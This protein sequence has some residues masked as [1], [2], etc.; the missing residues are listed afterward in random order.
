MTSGDLEQIDPGRWRDRATG[1]VLVRG[2]ALLH[3]VFQAKYSALNP[4][5][6]TGDPAARGRWDIPEHVTLY[7]GA[8]PDAALVEALASV[9]PAR[10]DFAAI[11]P[12]NPPSGDPVGREWEQLGHMPP[13][14]IARSWRVARK[15]TT[16][17]LRRGATP[18]FVDVGHAETVAALRRAVDAWAPTPELQNDP[19]RVD[20]SLLAGSDRH[21]T[22]A[23]GAWI[24]R[25]LLTDGS[26]PSGVRF[27]SKH[28]T[29][30][31]CWAVWIPLNGETDRERSAASSRRPPP[32]TPR[33]TSWRTPR[34]SCERAAC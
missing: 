3:R 11:F 4:P 26:E 6:P 33:S 32:S 31:I 21:A 18:W 30:L 10:I 29:S 14:Q 8:T 2:P 12:G 5:I 25:Q 20:L 1:L 22:V 16:L 13:G 28:G 23:A 15:L 19:P 17:R 7:G 34:H 9:N 27:A 24:R